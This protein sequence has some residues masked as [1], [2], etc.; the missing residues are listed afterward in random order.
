MELDAAAL[1][2]FFF[3]HTTAPSLC[4]VDLFGVQQAS[5]QPA[6][7]RI[8]GLSASAQMSTTVLAISAYYHDSSAAL[9]VDGVIASAAQEERF[10]RKKHDTAFP[11][12]AAHYCLQE[13]GVDIAQLD[14]IAGYG[15]GTGSSCDRYGARAV[16]GRNH[17]PQS[18]RFARHF[19]C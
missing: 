4:V 14:H 6:P 13:A 19:N 12:N 15:A 16:S 8:D 10:T 1:C 7:L 5:P 17:G 9:I 11:V 18:K 2:R 3:Y